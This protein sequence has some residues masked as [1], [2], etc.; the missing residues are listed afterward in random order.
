M[1]E[2]IGSWQRTVSAADTNI[3]AIPFYPLY[4]ANEISLTAVSTLGGAT[5]VLRIAQLV[6][7]NN[8]GGMSPSL[9]F[10]SVA[11]AD[12]GALFSGTLD[13]WIGGPVVGKEFGIKVDSLTNG[14]TWTITAICLRNRRS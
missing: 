3:L 6:G 5:I 13:T 12:E 2:A 7:Q 8:I 9:T 11:T 10:A 4:D 14:S 1:L